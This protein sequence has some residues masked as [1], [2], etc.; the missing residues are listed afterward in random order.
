MTGASARRW[1]S[2][3]PTPR[4]VRSYVSP[5]SASCE[6][7]RIPPMTTNPAERLGDLLDLEQIEGNIFR[8]RSP[9]ESLQ[10]VFG[11]AVGGQAPGRA[12]RTPGGGR[13]GGYLL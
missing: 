7:R 8:G 11:G 9:Q 1:T 5:T 2:R 12:G 4:D 10:R 3:P 13:P 6:H